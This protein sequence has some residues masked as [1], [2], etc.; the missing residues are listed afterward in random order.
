MSRPCPGQITIGPRIF[1]HARRRACEP[2][3]SLESI[4][5]GQFRLGF[6]RKL[7]T[8]LMD[9]CSIDPDFGRRGYPEPNLITVDSHHRD[10][11]AAID[12]DLFADFSRE[13]EHDL[14]LHDG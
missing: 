2:F 12:N 7:L 4:R 10:R 13:N 8:A 3:A 9:F 1:P 14:Y 6:L 11:D 5:A